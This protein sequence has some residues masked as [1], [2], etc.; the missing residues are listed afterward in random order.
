MSDDYSVIGLEPESA[1]EYVTAVM[2]TLKTTTAKRIG[3][4]KESE[5]WLSRVKLATEKGRP[6]LAS[7]AQERADALSEQ[8]AKL[9]SEEL[10]YRDGIARMMVQL[11]S[12]EGRPQLSGVDADLLLAQME[13][14]VGEHA[15]TDEEFRKAEADWA[16]DDLKKAQ[17]EGK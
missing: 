2:T 16:L 15:Q 1:R 6:D 3:V 8:I 5:R 17:D 10:E 11:K 13:M 9:K 12:I 14:L 7:G 4:E